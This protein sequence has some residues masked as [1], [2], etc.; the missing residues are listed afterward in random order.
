MFMARAATST[1]GT[2]T[3]LFLNFSS[4]ALMAGSM[5]SRRI[6]AAEI[7]SSMAACIVSQ[8]FL[9][10]P[11]WINWSISWILLMC[12]PSTFLISLSRCVVCIPLS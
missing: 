12:Y 11:C 10:R 4:M 2:N 1:S 9:P 7:P 6:S 3:S 8:T 5:P